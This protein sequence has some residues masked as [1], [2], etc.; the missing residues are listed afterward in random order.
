MS[1]APKGSEHLQSYH[2]GL[3]GL[4]AWFGLPL[5]LSCLVACFN[6]PGFIVQWFEDRMHSAEDAF[7][8]KSNKYVVAIHN[9]AEGDI[10]AASNVKV[11]DLK[12]FH[13]LGSVP[14]TLNQVIGRRAAHAIPADQPIIEYHLDEQPT[15]TE[16]A[17]EDR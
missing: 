6:A 11:V 10:L 4:V 2:N 3:I 9:I 17:K 15:A 12:M 13:V 7:V 16:P 8:F 14:E 5:V 1:Q